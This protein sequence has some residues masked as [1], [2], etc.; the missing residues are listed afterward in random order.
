M[1]D[2]VNILFRRAGKIRKNKKKAQAE[3]EAGIDVQK[4][5]HR[6]LFSEDGG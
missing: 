2:A 3:K 4:N 1:Y 6:L 5:N